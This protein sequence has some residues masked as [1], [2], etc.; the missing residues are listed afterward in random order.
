MAI[1][2]VSGSTRGASTNGALLRTAAAE[3]PDGVEAE[4][5]AG[6]TTLPHFNPETTTIRCRPRS[7]ICGRGSARRTPC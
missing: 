4:L 3:P 1:L 5:Y 7:R 6:M 2:L